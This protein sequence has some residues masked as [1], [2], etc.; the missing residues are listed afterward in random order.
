MKANVEEFQQLEG[1]TCD[2]LEEVRKML[3]LLNGPFNSSAKTEL[4][5]QTFSRANQHLDDC[6]NSLQKLEDSASKVLTSTTCKGRPLITGSIKQLKDETSVVQK[7]LAA[8]D[9]KVR[10]FV[11]YDKY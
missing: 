6:T 3:D 10:R 4:A 5:K 7:R 8:E 1:L 2:Q 9:E 11:L